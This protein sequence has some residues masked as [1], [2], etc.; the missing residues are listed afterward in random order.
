MVRQ[1]RYHCATDQ[2]ISGC[3]FPQVLFL[4]QL[5]DLH[6][7]E[8]AARDGGGGRSYA[9]GRVRGGRY[10][11]HGGGKHY[12]YK[13]RDHGYYDHHKRY[14][15]YGRYRRYGYGYGWYGSYG[16]YGGGC[17]WLYRNAVATHSTYWWNRYYECVGYY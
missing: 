6:P 3:A 16:Y 1:V 15:Y 7:L 5:I 8:I 2:V 10:Y 13:G 14:G 17:G 4:V 12:A 9:Y 11:G